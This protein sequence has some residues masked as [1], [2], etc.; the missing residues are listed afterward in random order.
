[1]EIGNFGVSGT[2]SAKGKSLKSLV[3]CYRYQKLAQELIRDWDTDG[4]QQITV[5]EFTTAIA[6]L[7]S[8]DFNQVRVQHFG[9]DLCVVHYMCALEDVHVSVHSELAAATTRFAIV[10]RPLFR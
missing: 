1:M 3:L 6:Q 8:L 2:L 7:L 4:D 10:G 9:L 5:S